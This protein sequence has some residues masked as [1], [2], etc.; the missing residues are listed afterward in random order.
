M[1]Y[2]ADRDGQPYLKETEDRVRSAESSAESS[3]AGADSI[4]PPTANP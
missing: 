3:V 2:T 4:N 1:R